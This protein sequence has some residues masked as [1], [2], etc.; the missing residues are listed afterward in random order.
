MTNNKF[1]QTKELS[2]LTEKEWESICSNCGKCCLVK[3]EDEED[4]AVYY[5]NIVCKYFDQ[6]SCKC[7]EYANRRK[8]VPECLKLDKDNIHEISW[9]PKS[10]AYRILAETGDL[11]DWH[12]LVSKK[13]LDSKFSIKD[14]CVSQL[15]VNEEDWEDYLVEEDDFDR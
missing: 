11:P 1:W 7:K 10:C 3:L 13:E 9:M 12:P 6:Q 5:T 14:K 4:G 2:D 15:E 8:L